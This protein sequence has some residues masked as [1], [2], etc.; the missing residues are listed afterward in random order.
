M[1]RPVVLILKPPNILDSYTVTAIADF[2]DDRPEF[3]PILREVIEADADG[4]WAFEDIDCDSGHFGELVSREFVES[5]EDGYRLTDRTAVRAALEGDSETAETDDEAGVSNGERVDFDVDLS[6]VRAPVFGRNTLFA[7]LLVASLGFLVFVRS[8]TYDSV[9]REDHVVPTSNDPFHYF[10]WV[11][12]LLAESPGYLNLPEIASVLAS[13]TSGEPFV[14]IVGWWVTAL[15]GSDTAGATLAVFP[16]VSAVLTAALLAW[17]AHA[18]TQDQRVTVLST[19][20]LAAMPANFLYTHLGFFDHHH[21]DFLWLALMTATLVWLAR[22]RHQTAMEEHLTKPQT[23]AVTG[24]LGVATAGSMLSWNGAP[25]LLI[26]VAVYAVVAFPS[27]LRIGDSPLRASLPLVAGLL[28]G[29]TVGVVIHVWAGLQEFPVVLAPGLVAGGALTVALVSEATDRLEKPPH[30]ALG[31]AVGAG[32]GVVAVLGVV[33]PNVFARFSRRFFE[34]LL[35]REVASETRGLFVPEL[36][37]NFGPF[38]QFG[39]LALVLFPALVYVTWQCLIRYEPVWLVPTSFAWAFLGF[40]TVQRRFAG[41][42]SMFAAFFA[43][44]GIIW[45]GS[46]VSLCRPLDCFGDPSPVSIQVERNSLFIARSVAIVVL[47]VVAVAASG[48]VISDMLGAVPTSDSQYE[49]AQWIEDNSEGD[50]YVLSKWEQNRMYNYIVWNGGD[51]YNYAQDTYWPLLNNGGMDARYSNLTETD[52]ID[53]SHE[54]RHDSV[55]YLVINE[56]GAQNIYIDTGY[57]QLFQLDGSARAE[58]DGLSHYR[59]VYVSENGTHKLFQPVR[60]AVI[61]GTA[62]PGTTVEVSTQVEL[63]HE[64]FE[65]VRR[66][67]ASEDGS[68]DVRVPYPGTYQT[69]TDETATVSESD[70]ERGKTVSAE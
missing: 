45:L 8:L 2:L 70:V 56:I 52:G 19:F 44:V 63:D 36:G 58:F 16:V 21:L 48:I 66:T 26:G 28:V 35:G 4:P 57:G 11:N 33:A 20:A 62:E 41:E 15:F 42:L 46:R 14:Y 68:Y 64:E 10:Y 13:R 40:A 53:S 61:T 67:S 34:D 29:A 25:L 31:A 1:H 23:W 43:A 17:M 59:L 22:D 50:P 54:R 7:L 69:S 27:T 37:I 60:G 32:L 39:L 9:F 49:T 38:E 47:L 12:Q 5:V 6:N 3:E 55:D 65:Y 24:L 51:A 30:V 18:V